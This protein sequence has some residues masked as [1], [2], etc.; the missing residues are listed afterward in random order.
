M[1]R[2]ILMI[3]IISLSNCSPL[4]TERPDINLPG[5]YR[6]SP[7][8]SSAKVNLSEWWKDFQDERLNG[9]VGE[10]LRKNH[11]I[12]LAVERV[13]E[14]RARLSVARADLFP[15]IDIQANISRQKQTFL[16]PQAGGRASLLINTLSLTPVASYELDLW[17]KLSSSKK[18]ALER[19]LA[20]DENK[21]TVMQTVVADLVTLYF[22]KIGLERKLHITKA[23]I[24]NSKTNLQLIERR[25]RRGLANY[26][27]VLQARSHLAESESIVPAMERQI[28]TLSQRITLLTG[29]YPEIEEGNPPD[30]D[31]LDLLPPVTAGLP[32]ELLLRRPDIR[33]KAAETRAFFEELKVAHAKRFPRIN[34]TGNYGWISDELRNLFRPESLLWQISAGVFQPLFD[35]G[36]LK[37]TEDISL[38]RYRQ[39]IISYGKTMLQAFYEVENALVKRQKLYEERAHLLELLSEVE[40]TYST[41]QSRYRR[42][43]VDLLRVLEL[44][45]QV[46]QTRER[47]IDVETEILTNRVFLYRALG[48]KWTDLEES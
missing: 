28:G 11:D 9:L 44:E 8:D 32:S 14:A 36:K 7:P 3:L 23:R 16:S 30:L 22:Q 34:L 6:N 37:S 46:F 40:K 47:L 29:A 41:S 48:G 24:E 18:A 45:R 25:Y 2:L 15:S 21:R 35:A 43:L 4:R 19:L 33:A 39:S 1:K 13:I 10:A 42:G 26:L 5:L 31:Y 12:R 17:G 20:T 38:S 27:D